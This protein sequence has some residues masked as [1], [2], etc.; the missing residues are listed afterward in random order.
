MERGTVFGAQ[1]VLENE[2]AELLL[3][4]IGWAERVRFGVSGTESDQAA[5]RLARA[6]T[7]RRRYL[8]FEGHYH[9]WLDNVLVATTDGRTTPASI[10]QDPAALDPM[11][12][13]P[14][15]DPDALEAAFAAHGDDLAAVICEP[16]M[17]NNG[18]I[19]P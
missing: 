14:F 4:T 19:P 3:D 18:A 11:I 17:C 13:I 8:R 6:A 10:G 12:V 15:N 5:I 2:A 16:M 7:G 9:G 1:H